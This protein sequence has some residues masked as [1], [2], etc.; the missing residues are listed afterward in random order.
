MHTN[1]FS[2]LFNHVK[3]LDVTLRDGGYKTNFHFSPEIVKQIITTADKAGIDYVEVG[4]RNGNWYTVADIGPSGLCAN[5]YL[6]SCRRYASST[7]L[8]VMFHPKN[9]QPTDLKEM[10]DCG[11]NGVRISF[12]GNDHDLGF[13]Y[14]SLAKQQNFDV[15]TNITHVAR[16]SLEELDQLINQIAQAGSDT[17][18]LADTTGHLTPDR[19]AALF[20]Y[21]TQKYSVKFGFHAHDNLFLA[22]ANA[23]AAMQN[24]ATYIDGT[25]SGLG[26]GVGNLHLEGV[27]ALMCSQGYMK[28]DLC[29]ILKMADVIYM[30]IQK[31]TQHLPLQAMI[32][33]AF[34]ISTRDAL[35]YSLPL[36]DFYKSV[37][38]LHAEN[39]SSNSNG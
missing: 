9:M 30:Q 29:A 18:G 32:M 15:F 23:L 14:V 6:Q 17:I 10:R 26:K 8:A 5:D 27:V 38:A 11:V 35:D 16:K 24:G 3:L 7:K 39:I 25:L 33:G 4:Y 36:E 1:I 19:T 28:Y 22:Q 37:Q 20:A 12:P 2:T 31:S 34:N 13:R 21:F